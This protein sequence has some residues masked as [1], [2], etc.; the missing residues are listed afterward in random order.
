MASN[1][2]ERSP[3]PAVARALTVL[4]TLVGADEP[5][6]LT[7]LAKKTKIPLATCAAIVYTLE[8]RGYASRR[9]VGRSHFW[10]PTLRLYGLATQLVRKID[11]SEIAQPQLRGLADTLGMP[12]HVGVLNGAD[13]RLRGEGRAAR[14]HP[15][16]H[17]LRQGGAVQPDRPRSRHRRIPARQRGRAAARPARRG[18]GPKA[19]PPTVDASGRRWRPYASRVMRW[20]TRRRRPRSPAWRRRSSTR[21]ARWPGPSASPASPASSGT[22]AQR[23]PDRPDLLGPLHLPQTR[24]RRRRRQLGHRLLTAIHHKIT[25]VSSFVRQ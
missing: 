8:E 5:L 23:G 2:T 3:S 14:F 21:R 9:I 6:T 11:L 7:S 19:P 16:R 24:L 22:S 10:R 15:V 17:L 20:R 13:D 1:E 4:E 18:T 12:A 25:G